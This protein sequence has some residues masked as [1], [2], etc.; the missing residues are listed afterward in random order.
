MNPNGDHSSEDVAKAEARRRQVFRRTVL[1]V[2]LCIVALIGVRV[3][4]GY[5]AGRRLQAEID[6][7][8]AAGEPILVDD[9]NPTTSIPDAVNAAVLYTQ[10]SAAIVRQTNT[11]ISF[12]DAIDDPRVCAVYPDDVRAILKANAKSLKLIRLARDL[13]EADW[14]IRFTSPMINVLLPSLSQQRRLSRLAALA[15]MFQHQDGDHAEAIETQ[16]DMH[17]MAAKLGGRVNVALI[18]HLVTIAIEALAV[19][20]LEGITPTLAILDGRIDQ[21]LPDHHATREQ[22]EAL[23]HTLLDEQAIRSSW[24]HAMYGERAMQLDSV[25]MVISGNIGAMMGPGPGVPG[26]VG[27]VSLIRPSF[28]LDA[29]RMMRCTTKLCEA[30]LAPNWSKAQE[31]AQAGELPLPKSEIDRLTHNMSNILVPSLQRA[32]TL[33]FRLLAERRMAATALAIRL[34]ELDHGRRPTSLDELVP[35]YLEALPIDPFATDG[36][37]FGY[38]PDGSQS[39]LYSIGDDGRDDGGEFALRQGGT[40]DV[41]QKDIPY[42]LNGDRPRPPLTLDSAE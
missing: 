32:L 12:E 2:I 9:F 5:E 24:R 10:A 21:Q 1:A 3:W 8:R 38:K 14:G 36:R 16:R 39:I 33:H 31:M 20:R 42:F 30:G 15:A 27:L 18:T 13:P 28:E 35:N 23:L 34:Y 25:L 4:W 41:E 7:C 6:R 22:I 17:A 11:A 37:T 26:G 29:V 19:S 40:V